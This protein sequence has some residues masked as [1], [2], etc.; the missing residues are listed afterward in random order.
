[1]KAI[2]SF[3]PAET[4]LIHHSCSPANQG[5]WFKRKPEDGK[6]GEAVGEF[7]A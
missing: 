4:G 2:V 5:G 1:M 3:V 7:L 6:K